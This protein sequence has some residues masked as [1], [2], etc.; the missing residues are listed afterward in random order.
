MKRKILSLGIAMVLI[1]VISLAVGSRTAQASNVW[2]AESA[3]QSVATETGTNTSLISFNRKQLVD[4]IYKYT[5]ILKVGPGEFDKIG[6]YRVVKEKMPWIPIIASKAV[7]LVHGDATNFD[8]SFLGSTLSHQ[9]P[10]DQSLGIFL[11]KNNVDVWGVDRRWTFV[12]DYYP[13]TEYPYCYVEGCTFMKNWNTALHVSDIK[14]G[15]K[16]ARTVRGLSGSGF[17]KILMLGHSRGAE[18]AYAYANDETQAPEFLRDLKGIIPVDIVLKFDPVNAAEQIRNACKRYDS[19]VHC[20]LNQGI[21]FLDDALVVKTLAGLAQADPDSPSPF[22]PGLTNKQALLFAVS[23]TYQ[24]ELYPDPANACSPA[25]EDLLRL[26]TIP[27]YHYLAGAFDQFGIPTGL[28]FTNLNFLF[29]LT[30]FTPSFQSIGEAIDGEALWCNQI[31]VPFDDHL[32]A[33]RIPVLYV[34][35]GGGFGEF[36]KY[37]LT[38][39]GSPDKNS[40]VVQTDPTDRALDYGHADVLWANNA[41]S[42]VW[43]PIYNWIIRH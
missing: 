37:S 9:V 26:P 42:L 24:T 43:V 36:G 32:S 4:N 21:F 7:V 31:D 15:V 27:F 14:A 2:W 11:A 30:S 10:V 13:G 6:V 17:G 34:G 38:L 8:T 3:I 29:D 40:L 35:A 22:L 33:I 20:K 1:L 19:L 16:L 18:F 28:Q 25:P 41:K 23:A 5:W 12:P 39:L